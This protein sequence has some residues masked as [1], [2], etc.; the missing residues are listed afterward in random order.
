VASRCGSKYH[1]QS[2]SIFNERFNMLQSISTRGRK[3]QREN[4]VELEHGL[5]H[6]IPVDYGR[7]LLDNNGG[8]PQQ[9]C[10]E[11]QNTEGTNIGS[12]IAIRWLYSIGGPENRSDYIKECYG[13]ESNYVAYFGRIP[14]N[15]L[16]IGEDSGGNQ[17]CISLY[18]EDVGSIWYW[19]HDAET[20]PP[21]YSNCYKIAD[22]FQA[23]LDGLFE[24]DYEHDI[25]IP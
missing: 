5:G 3:L 4:I 7:F 20:F 17:I 23:L 9:N 11:V 14:E 15:F 8:E 2:F 16:P 12:V 13:I 6:K 24:Y 22:S 1:L 19:D 21:D 18:G 10:H 25:R